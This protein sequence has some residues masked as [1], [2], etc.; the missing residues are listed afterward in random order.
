[1]VA[2]LLAA[3]LTAAAPTTAGNRVEAHRDAAKL[4]R[5]AVL[6]PGS[7][8]SSTAPNEL[9][10]PFQTPGTTA[11]VDE[12]R[13]WRVAD[14]LAQVDAFEKAHAPR[15]SRLNAWSTGTGPDGLDFALPAL[16]GR[17]SSRDVVVTMAA[18][19]GGGTGIRVDAQVVW[20]LTRPRSEVVPP[21]VAEV[22]VGSH[23]VV[24]AEKV[25]TIVRWF[26]ALPV[27]QPG[28]TFSCPALVA[29]PK[30]ALAFRGPH[31]VLA[32]A[33]FGAD[34]P[35]HSLVSAPCTPIRFSI[36]THREDELVGGRFFLHV[37]RLLG[38]KLL[39]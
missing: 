18:L 5:L 2:L 30:I 25:A 39:R 31:G 23:R 36:G 20:V 11:L 8:R 9:H 35:N 10:S 24:S 13:L 27:V 17:L 33:S 26:D 16:P 14:S 7:R 4:V 19:A 12:H 22:D 15:G 37:Q 34:T 38:V 28:A 3:A 29:G 21:A 1:M 32:R 6:P